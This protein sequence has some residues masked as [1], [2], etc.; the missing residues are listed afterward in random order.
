MLP[1]NLC[2]CLCSL[3][4]DRDRLTFSCIMRFIGV[5]LDSYEIRTSVIRSKARLTYSEV[6]K[7]LAGKAVS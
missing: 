5:K 4:P 2:N 1:E 7:A 6:N 3:M